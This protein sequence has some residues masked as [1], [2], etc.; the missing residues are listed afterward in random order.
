MSLLQEIQNFP[1]DLNK[2][3]N[4][5]DMSEILE[6]YC[7][8]ISK[9]PQQNV[10][11]YVLDCDK[12]RWKSQKDDFGKPKEY[13]LNNGHVFSGVMNDEKLFNKF[14]DWFEDTYILDDDLSK[15]ESIQNTIEKHLDSRCEGMV[16]SHLLDKGLET[17]KD[18]ETVQNELFKIDE[19]NDKEIVDNYNA[20]INGEKV[21]LS[22]LS[23]EFEKALQKTCYI[24]ANQ[25]DPL[26]VAEYISK[27]L[28]LRFNKDVSTDIYLYNDFSEGNNK[29]VNISEPNYIHLINTL[30]YSLQ[31]AVNYITENTRFGLT[32][33]D[34]IVE[35]LGLN[36]ASDY[37][38]E[39]IKEDID[40]DSKDFDQSIDKNLGKEL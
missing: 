15:F 38:I 39:D 29:K 21:R 27:D 34:S 40:D 16:I 22:F 19:R 8:R 6:K 14:I 33:E 3:Y 25:H 11:D 23:R 12:E 7:E 5:T 31:N 9:L 30:S 18:K 4:R 17:M 2:K 1:N 36:E 37:E 13:V 32:D 28:D 10:S 24:I 35:A 20:R 26:D